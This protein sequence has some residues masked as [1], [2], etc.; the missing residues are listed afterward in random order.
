MAK[1]VVRKTLKKCVVVPSGVFAGEAKVAIMKPRGPVRSQPIATVA[2]GTSSPSE[3]KEVPLQRKK[4]RVA[5]K[6]EFV[7]Q[8]SNASSSL[9]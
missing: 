6:Q 5:I 7:D 9:G 1:E 4:C 8:G 3:L 2:A